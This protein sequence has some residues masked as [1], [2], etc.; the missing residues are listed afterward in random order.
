MFW[1][2]GCR[3]PLAFRPP[4][5]TALCSSTMT[6]TTMTSTTSTSTSMPLKPSLVTNPHSPS[7]STLPS[8]I[9]PTLRSLYQRAA[10]AFIQKDIALTYSLLESAFSMLHPPSSSI[11]D[12]LDS[13]R[14]KWDILRI[15]LESTVYC[16]STES[17]ADSKSLPTP[18][19]DSM[20]LARPIIVNEMHA[21]SMQLF[22]PTG[23]RHRAA[24]LPAQIITTLALASYKL[25]CAELSRNI[26]EDWLAQRGQ[27]EHVREDAV[28]YEKVLD[29]YC[30][31]VL[32]S[33]GAWDY[34]HDFLEYEIELP[35]ISRQVSPRNHHQFATLSHQVLLQ[36]L[37][38]A[39]AE[40][41]EKHTTQTQ[42]STESTRSAISS[43][44]SSSSQSTPN[45]TPSPSPSTSS[46]SSADTNSTR[47]VV[48]RNSRINNAARVSALTPSRTPPPS[49]P[50]GSL[51]HVNG[52]ALHALS[53][54]SSSKGKGKAPAVQSSKQRGTSRVHTRDHSRE[55]ALAGRPDVASVTYTDVF[56][57]MKTYLQPHLTTSK[58][59]FVFLLIVFP[60][61]SFVFRIRRRRSLGL[62]G[63]ASAAA[64]ANALMRP[65]GSGS[66]TTGGPPS[67]VN[68]VRRRLRAQESG[69]NVLSSV[70]R[71]I[72]QSI[73]DAV[74]MAGG[75]LV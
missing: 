13:Q 5:S 34:A 33:L 14:R 63:T 39:L 32:P 3:C 68:E 24:Y 43:E 48:P 45:R 42:R 61:L 71:E 30:L 53:P 70:L 57:L 73:S 46:S 17:S 6:T 49:T 65:S 25:D 54:E 12:V 44:P 1:P 58:L 55:S 19:R 69:S 28:G 59:V 31:H 4:S 41:Y 37:R 60:V 18:L 38:A 8:A 66:S 11:Q 15:T 27:V 10:R 56:S 74:R 75:G 64:G 29:L 72:Y 21:R 50:N 47:T 16:S 35:S 52:D 62:A 36:R 9:P 2:G 67:A 7:T 23:M 22:T 51:H 20:M 26:I 40:Q